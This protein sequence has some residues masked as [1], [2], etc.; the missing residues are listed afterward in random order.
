MAAADRRTGRQRRAGA[1][2][3]TERRTACRLC[4]SSGEVLWPE[5]VDGL[6]DVE[7]SW[8]VLRCRAFACGTLWL[9]PQPIEA[10]IG[11]AYARYYTHPSE[12]GASPG[13]L[14]GALRRAYALGQR[15]YLADRY[16][17]PAV[18]GW[19][20]GVA[21]ALVRVWPGRRADTEFV[22]FYQAG[23]RGGRLLDVGCGS[24]KAV[25]RLRELGWDARGLELDPVAVEA[26]RAAGL[27]VEQGD[28]STAGLPE[29]AFDVV[30]LS[31]VIEHVHDP[32]ALLQECRRVL[33]PGGRIVVV[34]P[35]AESWLH[36]R[37]GRLWLGLDP[38]RHLHVFTL[39]SLAR[40]AH[41]A[42]LQIVRLDTTIRGA[43]S[44]ALAAAALKADG[45]FHPASRPSRWTR[46]RA[47]VVQ[48]LAAWRMWA[49]PREGEDLVLQ[50]TRR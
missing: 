40:L 19:R 49:R 50:A 15:R 43:N 5:V 18:P 32:Q 28:L 46:A 30:T 48:Q 45:R 26:A 22:A 35:N 44:V 38:P 9:D 47:E 3:R 11:D 29:A 24:G 21:A 1:V 16:G 12:Q 33:R 7:G 41:A 42:E 31:H 34:T 25:R 6:F 8:N 37:Y 10:D 23:R 39:A 20:A 2:M 14:P 13:G 36:R 4:G 17:Y 27:P